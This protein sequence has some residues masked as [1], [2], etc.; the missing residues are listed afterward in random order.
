MAEDVRLALGELLRQA[1]GAVFYGAGWRRCRVH[2]LRN[3]LAL[4]PSLRPADQRGG[5]T[6]VAAGRRRLP[7]PLAAPGRPARPRRGRRA[8]S[9]GVPAGAA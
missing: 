4:V 1:I 6:A 5:E 2:V 8:G 9:P 3:A 7:G